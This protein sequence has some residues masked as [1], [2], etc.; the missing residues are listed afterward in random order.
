MVEMFVSW[1][2]EKRQVLSTNHL[3]FQNKAF[4][5]LLMQ[6]RKNSGLKT[7]SSGTTVLKFI[8]AE[9]WPLSITFCFLESG[10]SFSS[11]FSFY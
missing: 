5:K 10:K 3:E 4:D 1:K 7:D 8:P 2:I 11:W 9:Y 6:I